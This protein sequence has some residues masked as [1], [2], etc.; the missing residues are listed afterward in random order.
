MYLTG[1]TMPGLGVPL[2]PG[3]K[4]G[5]GGQLFL[6]LNLMQSL[7]NMDLSSAPEAFAVPADTTMY[8]LLSFN[9]HEGRWEGPD[10][11]GAGGVQHRVHADNAVSTIMA[12][13]FGGSWREQT[14]G[15]A[16]WESCI[17]HVRSGNSYHFALVALPQDLE[18]GFTREDMHAVGDD[19]GL[20]L[21]SDG[22]DLFDFPE[23]MAFVADGLEPDHYA[24]PDHDAELE[25]PSS[26]AEYGHMQTFVNHVITGDPLVDEELSMANTPVAGRPGQHARGEQARLF[27]TDLEASLSNTR[28]PLPPAL[29]FAP[30]HAEPPVLAERVSRC[31]RFRLPGVSED[32]PADAPDSVPAEPGLPPDDAEPGLPPDDA[33]PGLEQNLDNFLQFLLQR[34]KIATVKGANEMFKV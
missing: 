4:R 32:A 15:H 5:G 11:P 13:T 12:S 22:L 10:A 20:G 8:V 23:D 25:A 6:T 28:G 24:E 19:G 27:E 21:I 9:A 26:A 18:P 29:L 2:T 1:D 34:A 3:G 7:L 16:F 14:G 31:L 17:V 33:E 30:Q